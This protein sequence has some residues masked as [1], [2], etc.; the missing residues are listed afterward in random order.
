MGSKKRAEPR[1]ENRDCLNADDV[2]KIQKAL[3]QVWSWSHS[4]RLVLKRCDLGG[5]YSR[6]EK[7]RKKV[8]KV[9][10][11]H[12][13]A[14]GTFDGEYIARLFVPSTSMQGLCAICHKIKTKADLKTIKAKRSNVIED[15][16]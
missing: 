16:F 2:K 12:I 6:C 13:V 10:V 3:R 11:D 9:H 8:P 7:C 15:F 4:R 5:G 1:A 14:V